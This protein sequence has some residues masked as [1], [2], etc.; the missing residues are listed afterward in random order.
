M[1]YYCHLLS[2]PA[3]KENA[4]SGGDQHYGLHYHH[5]YFLQ[6]TPEQ[7]NEIIEELKQIDVGIGWVSFSLWLLTVAVSFKK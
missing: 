5:H 6:M 3:H 2:H 4:M 7:A 1:D